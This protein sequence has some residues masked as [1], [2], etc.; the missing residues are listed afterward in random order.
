MWMK[1]I[2]RAIEAANDQFVTVQANVLEVGLAELNSL[3][4]GRVRSQLERCQ[5]YATK[6]AELPPACCRLFTVPDV[7]FSLNKTG[8]RLSVTLQAS[9]GLVSSLL[10]ASAMV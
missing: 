8:R 5:A 9:Q 2:N 3:P 1:F 6:W 7:G 10:P 4:V